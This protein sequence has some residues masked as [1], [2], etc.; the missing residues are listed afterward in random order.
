MQIMV[1]CSVEHQKCVRAPLLVLCVKREKVNESLRKMIFF[2]E[3]LPDI[4]Q[5]L[6]YNISQANILQK[7][8]FWVFAQNI[9]H[10]MC[11]SKICEKSKKSITNIEKWYFTSNLLWN[12]RQPLLQTLHTHIFDYNCQNELSSTICVFLCNLVV[13]H[14]ITFFE[15]FK[16]LL[17][18]SPLVIFF[19]TQLI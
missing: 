15:I 2:A 19:E 13:K 18:E 4:P 8:Q 16:M 11:F 9:C 12:L 10:C 3:T 17:R 7:L 14:K 1:F 5:K 6:C